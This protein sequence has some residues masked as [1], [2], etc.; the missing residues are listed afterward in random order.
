MLVDLATRPEVAAEEAAPRT[1]LRRR[2]ARVLIVVLPV[3]VAAVVLAGVYDAAANR[4]IADHLGLM[5][6]VLL[7]GLL[8]VGALWAPLRRQA[9]NAGSEPEDA[10]RT[11]MEPRDISPRALLLQVRSL[12]AT[13]AEED[14]R[15]DGVRRDAFSRA[16]EQVRREQSRVRVTLRVMRDVVAGQPGDVAVGRIEAA[17]DRLGADPGFARPLLSS[18]PPTAWAVTFAPTLALAVPAASGPAPAGVH[19]LADAGPADAVADT[20]AATPTE[21][22][23][24]LPVPPPPTPAAPTRRGRRLRRSVGV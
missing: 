10:P 9:E 21:P 17:L 5:A 3:S 19:V 11:E 12:E 4:M 16:E 7:A 22:A 1:P 23:R 15:L 14:Q 6:G 20:V 18:G 24:V 8:T 13:L 2:A